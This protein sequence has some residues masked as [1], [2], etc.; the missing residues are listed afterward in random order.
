MSIRAVTEADYPAIQALH[1]SVGW[2]AR[3]LAGWRWLHANPARAE[4]DAPG[5][6]VVD[7]PDGQPAAHVGNLIHRFNLDGRRLHAATGFSIIALPK[8]RGVAH[9]IIRTFSKQPEVFATYTFNANPLSQP[10]YGRLGMRPWPEQTHALKLS[11]RIDLSALAIGKG[12]RHLHAVAPD[13]VVRMGEQLMNDRL[14]QVPRLRLSPGVSILSRIG[15]GSP[16]DRF[17]QALGREGRLLG[18][19]SPAMLK[20]RL[21]DPDLT[22]P[23]LLLAF[24]RGDVITGYAMAQMAKSN[25]IEVPVLEIIDL[26]AL[27]WDD[28]A[29]PALMKAL[30]AAAR[31]LGAAKVRMQV[32]SPLMLDR[33]GDWA[34]T[35]AR[36]GG[37]GHCHIRFADDAPSPALWSPTP[38]DSD[39]AVCLRPLPLDAK[40]TGRIRSWVPLS[41]RPSRA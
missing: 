37:W 40:A 16:Y 32:V 9:R 18:D 26:E 25:I 5:G 36:E 14:G 21:A 10:L 6:W 3:S 28:E 7:G 12:L 30:T 24:R 39:Y 41:S 23:P 1:R 29:I 17:Q 33:L 19:R 38:F 27:A 31:P 35:A 34:G 13:L 15:E 8:V 22:T 20:W 2:P 4:I 11:W